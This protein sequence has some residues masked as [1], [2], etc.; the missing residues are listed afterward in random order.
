MVLVRQKNEKLIEYVMKQNEYEDTSLDLASKNKHE[1]I[2][3][4]LSQEIT[5]AKN[6]KVLCDLQFVM[7][8]FTY[9]TK[10]KKKSSILWSIFCCIAVKNTI[11]SFIITD[12]NY[13]EI[14]IFKGEPTLKIKRKKTNI[15]EYDDEIQIPQDE[16]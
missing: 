16:L 6:Q 4:L 13:S 14:H 10:K 8:M 5:N 2:V 12:Y 1:N 11:L 15:P 3:K 9:L 7:Q